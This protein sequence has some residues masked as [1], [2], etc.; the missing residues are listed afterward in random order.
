MLRIGTA[1]AEKGNVGHGHLKVGELALGSEIL[2][3]VLIVRG[4]EDG[5][6]L[7]INGAVHGDE[8]NGFMAVRNLAAR[9]DPN[10]L[11]GTLVATPLSN[12]LAV[13]W[14]NKINP[15]DF[16]DLDQ[17]FPGNAAGQYS[18]R[19][20]H[21]LFSEIREKANYLISFH[22]VAT[23]FTAE[24]YT[25]FKTSS[26]MG[27]SVAETVKGMALAFGVRA[28]CRV[29]LDTATG[30]IPGGVAGAIDVS[31]SLNGI[32]AIMAEVGS[33]GKFEAENIATAEAGLVNVM[34]HLGMLEGEPERPKEQLLITKR[35]FLYC[36]RG[37]FLVM[38][39]KPGAIVP[40]G[41]LIGRTIDLFEEL[42]RLEAE[43]DAYVIMSRTN[44]V[45]HTGDRAAFLGLEWQGVASGA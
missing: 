24:P 18:Q 28:N 4:S 42:E 3:P 15:Y 5:P 8:I 41:G 43:Q 39:T 30:E 22:T 26:S 33:G 16:L 37:G 29:N 45:V 34:R 11:K 27:A 6:T 38:D 1:Q 2:I 21:V 32:P 40:K 31:C 10:I 19:T 13:Q 12:P 9:L 7:W 44:P 25:V 14:R 35:A 17:Q 20:A 36:N 23:S